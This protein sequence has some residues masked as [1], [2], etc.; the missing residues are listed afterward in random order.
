MG[1][2]QG[3]ALL[4]APLAAQEGAPSLTLLIVIAPEAV[5]FRV[6]GLRPPF[7]GA[8]LVALEPHLAHYFVGLPPLLAGAAVLGV[9]RLASDVGDFVLDATGL[10]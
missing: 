3:L 10:Q 5:E 4:A 6:G 7:A 8:V 1:I 9:A 2:L